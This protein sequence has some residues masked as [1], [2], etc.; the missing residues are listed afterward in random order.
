MKSEN[1]FIRGVYE[2]YEEE[3]RRRE[4]V[5]R[6]I[7]NISRGAAVGLCASFAVFTAINLVPLAQSKNDMAFEAQVAE[8]ADADFEVYSYT[9]AADATGAV[10]FSAEVEEAAP[11]AENGVVKNG[12]PMLYGKLEAVECL[13]VDDSLKKGSAG[14]VYTACTDKGRFIYTLK[15]DYIR[16]ERGNGYELTENGEEM[17]RIYVNADADYAVISEESAGNGAVF[18]LTDSGEYIRYEYSGDSIIMI[19]SDKS[20]ESAKDVAASFEYEQFN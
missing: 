13:T 11:E 12:S 2:K 7:L 14:V 8:E 4:N 18:G 16:E 17:A 3:K 20:G 5:R 9:M 15:N 6:R 19:L 1:E 10:D